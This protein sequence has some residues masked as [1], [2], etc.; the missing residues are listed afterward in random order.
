VGGAPARIE[1]YAKKPA[2]AAITNQNTASIM[3]PIQT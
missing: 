3:K 1:R 2:A